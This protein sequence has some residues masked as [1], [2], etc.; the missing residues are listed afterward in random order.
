ME[1]AMSN[2]VKAITDADF[3]AEVLKSTELVLIYFWASW[4]G[5]CRLM[6]PLIN[7]AAQNYGD[8]IKVVKME[9]DPN[10]I[11]VG[12]YKVE[13]LPALRLFKNGEVIGSVEGIDSKQKIA[14]LVEPHL[15]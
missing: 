4:C 14:S 12:K 5:P 1:K 2:S 9:V 13:G 15:A 11:A 8:R 10:R 3:E 7:S 6:T